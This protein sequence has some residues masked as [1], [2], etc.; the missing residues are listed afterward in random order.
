MQHIPLTPELEK[1]IR[2]NLIAREKVPTNYNTYTVRVYSTGEIEGSDDGCA[3]FLAS[4]WLRG[5][6]LY[7]D[8]VGV[9]YAGY[10]EPAEGQSS[11]GWFRGYGEK[12]L[13]YLTAL[14]T[15]KAYSNLHPYMVDTDPQKIL[16]ARGF[17]FHNICDEN[18]NFGLFFAFMIAQRQPYEVRSQ[19][20]VFLHASEK[21]PMDIALLV[22]HLLSPYGNKVPD[23]R[24]VRKLQVHGDP[25]GHWPA[26]LFPK[27][28]LSGDTR[29]IKTIASGGS[30]GCFTDQQ[31]LQPSWNERQAENRYQRPLDEWVALFEKE[32]I[33]DEA[34]IAA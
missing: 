27:R 13:K 9:A 10:G 8:I 3:A 1:T 26:K 34:A 4:S 6:G 28:F 16:D 33:K 14:M 25:F 29:M 22:T 2:D 21:Y 18:F 24:W 12:A 23:D 32:R 7:G 19:M 15:T 30:Q 31:Y 17:I 11:H 20:D 5:P